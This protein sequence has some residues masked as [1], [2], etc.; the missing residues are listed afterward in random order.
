MGVYGKTPGSGEILP[1]FYE[2]PCLF[3]D[4]MNNEDI[5]A[6]SNVFRPDSQFNPG[7]LRG[8]LCPGDRLQDYREEI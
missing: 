6:F 4:S 5:V 3:F 8:I 2:F 1:P 7:G